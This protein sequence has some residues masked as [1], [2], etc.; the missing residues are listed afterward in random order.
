MFSKL[1][2][3]CKHRHLL[4][5]FK[6]I[7]RRSMLNMQFYPSFTRTKCKITRSKTESFRRFRLD[8][9]VIYTFCG[10]LTI[11]IKCLYPIFILVKLK[12][13]GNGEVCEILR[14][15]D[16]NIGFDDYDF[17]EPKYLHIFW[18]EDTRNSGS[19]IFHVRF[20]LKSDIENMGQSIFC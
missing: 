11:T 17:Y 14:K 16:N 20:W 2:V 6:F 9:L 5:N 7:K 8:H 3:F 15:L 4:Q 19:I 10:E 13:Y 12:I 1:P 18:V